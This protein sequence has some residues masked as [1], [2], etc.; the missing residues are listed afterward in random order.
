MFIDSCTTHVFTRTRAD[1]LI[2]NL[3]YPDKNRACYEY[4]IDVI[5]VNIEYSMGAANRT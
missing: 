5:A 2:N 3:P 4:V 1:N